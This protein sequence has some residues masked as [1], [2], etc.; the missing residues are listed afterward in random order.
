MSRR[1]MVRPL[2]TLDP[3]AFLFFDI[4]PPEVGEAGRDNVRD[5]APVGVVLPDEEVGYDDWLFRCCMFE[6]SL[7]DG[8]M[9]KLPLGVGG[10]RLLVSM[11]WGFTGA[12]AATGASGIE[13]C[14]VSWAM[15]C[16]L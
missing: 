12:E 14:V 11:G 2:G 10:S 13:G 6:R 15:G 7:L 8:D 1:V 9:R 4:G 16:V 3:L 5:V